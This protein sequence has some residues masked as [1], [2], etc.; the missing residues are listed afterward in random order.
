MDRKFVTDNDAA[1]ARLKA[2]VGGLNDEDIAR[3]VSPQWTVGVAFMHVAFW[4]RLWLAKF[5]EW[6][7]TGVVRLPELG[8]GVNA[9]NDG[10]LPWWRAIAPAQVRHEAIAAAEAVDSKVASLPDRVVEAV[11]AARPRTLMRAIHRREHLDKID[12]ALRRR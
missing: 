1:R 12:E 5:E 7:R 2:L 11:L 4:D 10:M 6:E 8:E 9:V 3:T